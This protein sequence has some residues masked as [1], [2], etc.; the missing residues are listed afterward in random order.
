[1]R[2]I[3]VIKADRAAGA[4]QHLLKLLAG[5][6]ARDID[7]QM[8]LLVEPKNDMQNYVQALKDLGVPVHRMVIYHHADVLIIKRLR[9]KLIELQPDIVHTHLIHADLYG[10]LVA[11]WAGVPIIVTSRHNDDAFRYRL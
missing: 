7:V 8:I 4:E 3:H 2:V 1:M 5:L 6:R 11:R 9:D 10:T